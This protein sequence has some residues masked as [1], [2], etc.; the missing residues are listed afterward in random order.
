MSGVSCLRQRQVRRSMEIGWSDISAASSVLAF[1][2]LEVHPAFL[3]ARR[4]SCD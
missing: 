1:S 4:M 3:A 2:L